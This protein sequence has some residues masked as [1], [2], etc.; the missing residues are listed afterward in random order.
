M[1]WTIVNA[2]FFTLGLFFWFSPLSKQLALRRLN[3]QDKWKATS[4]YL[5]LLDRLDIPKTTFTSNST[6][7]DHEPLPILRVP[8]GPEADAEWDRIGGSTKARPIVVSSAEI[9]RIGKDPSKAVK[10]P[11]KFGYGSDAYIAWTEVFHLLHCVDILRQ[12][13]YSDHYGSGHGGES[14][15]DHHSHA[16]HC[17]EVL[18]ESIKCSGSVDPILFVWVEGAGMP[19]PEFANKHLC[20]DFETVLE[21]VNKNGIPKEVF[22]EM[23]EPPPG[24]VPI[25]EFDI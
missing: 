17:L 1:R 6:F 18:A 21:Y 23:K 22:N 20:R 16:S 5:P 8:T 24:Y 9:H 3:D 11:E 4:V 12:H 13:V 25:P 7:Y 2:I 19:S 10:I 15:L 14:H